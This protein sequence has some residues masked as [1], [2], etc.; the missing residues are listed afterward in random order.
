MRRCWFVTVICKLFA[1][2]NNIKKPQQLQQP[3]PA[4]KIDC[5][6]IPVQMILL[7]SK[8]I[9]FNIWLNFKCSCFILF[10]GYF[11]TF[12]NYV[13][14]NMLNHSM[15]H[16]CSIIIFLKT[17]PNIFHIF[18]AEF[19][20][21]CRV[22]PLPLTLL[23]PISGLS[24]HRDVS[25][26]V[27]GQTGGTWGGAKESFENKAY[28]LGRVESGGRWRGASCWEKLILRITCGL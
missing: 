15:P 8:S 12:C 20:F 25:F 3:R 4:N 14:H 21:R 6:V 19:Y 16:S 10:F 7:I 13:D 5:F 11:W 2:R 23:I 28:L 18:W 17:S 24:D 27:R 1:I 9:S 22:L 26:D